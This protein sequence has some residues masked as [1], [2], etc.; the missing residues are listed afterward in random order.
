MTAPTARTGGPD[1]LIAALWMVGTLVS[2][3]V[4]MIAV[5]ELSTEMTN[6]EILTFRSLIGILVMTPIALRFGFA[7]LRTQRPGFHIARNIV[8]FGGSFAWMFGISLLPLAEVTA[9]EFTTPV[10]TALIAALFLGEK[11]SPHRVA[12]IVL[13]F[14]G[15]L[16]ILRPGA[17]AIHVAALVMIAGAICYAGSNCMVKS[18]T[19]TEAPWLILFYMQIVQLPLGLVPAMFDWVT[20]AWADAPWLVL[21]GVTVLTAHYSMARAFQLADA[22][23][24]IPLEFLRMPLVATIGW[25]VYSETFDPWVLAGAALIVGGTYYSVRREARGVPA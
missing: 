13:G 24:V 25:L 12:A 1:V 16:V 11:L 10:W 18:M 7:A 14:V 19:R 20:P 6:F 9:L 2:F 21:V 23:V 4:M 17:A 5:R 8:H 3:V 15:V 22:S